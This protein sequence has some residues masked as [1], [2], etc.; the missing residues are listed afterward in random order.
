[1][2]AGIISGYHRRGRY[3]VTT[4][5][6][7][8]RELVE[9]IKQ[10]HYLNAASPTACINAYGRAKNRLYELQISQHPHAVVMKVS[11]ADRRYQWRRRIELHIRQWFKDYNRTAFRGCVALYKKGLPVAV[12]LAWW[13][14]REG[15]RIKSYFLY[16]KIDADTSL[17]RMIA[18]PS[19]AT[20]QSPE[21]VSTLSPDVFR[22]LAKKVAHSIRDIHAAGWRHGDPHPGNFLTN[23]PRELNTDSAEAMTLYPVDYDHC[24]PV[25]IRAPSIRRFFNL[26]CLMHIRLLYVSDEDMLAYYFGRPASRFELK[27]LAFW[28]NGG[29]S[30]SRRSRAW[31]SP[32]PRGAHLQAQYRMKR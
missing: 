9:W 12:P 14:H 24:V 25:R 28:R 18:P 11:S 20:E 2:T 15:L 6:Q 16:Q 22:A 7:R 8:P 13:Q 17:S 32:R 1:M 10:C 5:T 21:I 23:Q 31:R 19:P 4:Y 29:I 27:T 26:K 3:L 30:L